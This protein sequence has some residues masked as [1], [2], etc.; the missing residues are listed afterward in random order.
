MAETKK[1]KVVEAF[2]LDGVTQE[3]GS[4]VELTEEQETEFAGKVEAATDAE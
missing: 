4:V 3:V 2:D 1:F